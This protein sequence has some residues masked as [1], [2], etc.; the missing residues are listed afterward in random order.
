MGKDAHASPTL[1][2][3]LMG[4]K[5]HLD[6]RADKVLSILQEILDVET[7]LGTARDD[8]DKIDSEMT[9][10][11]DRAEGALNPLLAVIARVESELRPRTPPAPVAG[12][13]AQTYRVYQKL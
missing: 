6:E 9:A 2:E 13:P 5:R 1:F 8:L 3:A 12:P 10:E 7:L 11:T 4:A